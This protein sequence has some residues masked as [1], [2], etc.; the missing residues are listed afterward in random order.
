MK[1]KCLYIE[2]PSGISGDMTIGA[3]LDLEIVDIEELRGV[4]DEL[5]ISN[6][7]L[8]SKS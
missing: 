3:F 7:E 6:I 5:K 1:N 2:C 4:V 8:T